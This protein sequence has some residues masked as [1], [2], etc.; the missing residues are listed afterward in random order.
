[1]YAQALRVLVV[2]DNSVST[3]VAQKI[4]AALG[5]ELVAVESGPDALRLLAEEAF[6]LVLIALG[7]PDFNIVEA[8]QSLRLLPGHAAT[9]IIGL[10]DRVS[11]DFRELCLEAGLIDAFAKPLRVQYFK[12]AFND[13]LK[14]PIPS[15]GDLPIAESQDS[16]LSERMLEGLR[17]IDD[18]KGVFVNE[19]IDLFESLTPAVMF[20]LGKALADNKEDES[21]SLAHKLKGMCRNLGILRLA[22]TLDNI[23]MFYGSLSPDK[24]LS[25]PM[26]IKLEFEEAVRCL[27][28][29]WYR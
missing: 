27:H 7:M 12:K 17:A 24:R 25:L 16:V 21:V 8:V 15:D 29:H 26:Q 23:E 4:A 20:R 11:G 2:D 13:C 14:L 28:A 6:D 10:T 22:S 19:L 18:N 5:Q 1:M 3:R 9:P